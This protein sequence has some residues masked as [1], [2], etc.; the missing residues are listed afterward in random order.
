MYCICVIAVGGLTSPV[1]GPYTEPLYTANEPPDS[2]Q[3]INSSV[4]CVDE[5]HQESVEKVITAWRS[6]KESDD[7]DEEEEADSD[8]SER[9]KPLCLQ[10]LIP[11]PNHKITPVPEL[12]LR[13][14]ERGEVSLS[15]LLIF[16]VSNVL[17]LLH[18]VF[19]FVCR[20]LPEQSVPASF[21]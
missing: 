7:E 12:E 18:N 10:K 2:L 8:K 14:L 1:K 15:F 17:Q 19:L 9:G 11:E 20:F 5:E 16:L 3:L 13:K 4:Y 6:V 21:C